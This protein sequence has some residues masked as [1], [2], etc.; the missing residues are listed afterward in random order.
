MANLNLK[1][2]QQNTFDAIVVGTGITG[3]WA[4]KELTEKGLKVLLLERGRNVEHPNYETATKNPWEFDHR[5]RLTQQDRDNHHIQTR[6]YSINGYCKHYYI[7]DKENPYEELKRYDWVRAN[8]V[9]GRSLLWARACYRWGNVDFEANAKDGY[10]VDW[11]IRYKDLEPWYGYVEKFIGVSGQSEAGIDHFPDMILQPPMEMNCVE[12]DF[13][14]KASKKFPDRLVTIG[15]TANLTAPVKGRGVCQTRN[16]CDRG[17]PYGAYFSTNASTLPAAFA[18]GNLTL[19]PN[20]LVN[21][22]LYDESKQ[23]ATG[24]EI[25]DTET[26]EVIEFYSSIIFLNAA[27]MATTFILLNSISKQFPNGLGNGSDQVGRNVMDHHKGA[28][29]SASVDGFE[30]QYYSGRRP[31]GIYVPRYRNFGEKRNYLRGFGLQGGA[32]RSGWW[33][34]LSTEAIG[35]NLKQVVQT[36]GGWNISLGGFGECLSYQNNRATLNTNLKDKYGRNTLSMD[37]EFHENEKKMHED[38]ADSAVEM[39]E[40]CGYKNVRRNS[41]ISFPGN[42]NHEMGTARM[43]RDPKTSV[44]NAFNQMHEVKNVFI[45]DGSCMTSS[46]N[47]NPSL[48]YMALTAR[49]CDYAVR[50]MKKGSI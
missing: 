27:T 18:T 46:G 49:A 50:E 34:A 30:D 44:L 40:A 45:T 4:A 24:V 41:G 28:G 33:N 15:R 8:V 19:R 9:G 23:R 12:K 14:A 17:C 20:S 31:T 21:R 29:A 26:N 39:L 43:G 1:A 42:A 11:P 48:T 47:V 13:K 6:H 32:G 36:P 25:I 10:G 7:N 5:G 22:V 3:G 16:Q 37:V 35:E 38:I 2:Q